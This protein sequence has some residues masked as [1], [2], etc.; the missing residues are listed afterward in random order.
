MTSRE[1][2]TDSGPVTT[3]KASPGATAA[4]LAERIAQLP[5]DA[6]FIGGFG[7][8]GVVLAFGPAD[9]SASDRDILAAVVAALAPQDFARPTAT[10][11]TATR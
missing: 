3:V 8:V 9:G 6:V 4:D 1:P 5:S 2:A 10:A 11:V 7:D